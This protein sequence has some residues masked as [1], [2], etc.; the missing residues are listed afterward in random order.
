MVRNQL[1]PYNEQNKK[2]LQIDGRM[3]I[4]QQL[5]NVGAQFIMRCDNLFN[6]RRKSARS[7]GDKVS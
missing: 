5:K 2:K 6:D 1:I 7:V 3:K 4:K